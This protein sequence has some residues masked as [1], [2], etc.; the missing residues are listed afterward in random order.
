VRIGEYFRYE[1][2]R[3]EPFTAGGVE[4]EPHARVAT[5]HT[6]Y[7][8]F[9]WNRPIALTVRRDGEEEAVIPIF[10]ATLIGQV[11]IYACG[12]IFGGLV[13]ALIIQ[14]RRSR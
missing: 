2:A 3:G 10:D 14:K 12:I 9:V 13:L 1:F 11:L 6:P 7:G 5:L 4:I 8:G